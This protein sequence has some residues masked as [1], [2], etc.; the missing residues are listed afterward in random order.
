MDLESKTDHTA[1]T[2][3]SFEMS[4]KDMP[5]KGLLASEFLSALREKWFNSHEFPAGTFIS[6]KKYKHPESKHK[7]IFY[8]FNNQLDYAL[9]HYF[10]KSKTTKGNVNKF[11]TNPLIAPLTKN[12]SYKNA[13]K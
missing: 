7:N 8:P 2:N 13:I 1:T 5:W 12:L 10:T 11:L 6:D 3:G 9:A 4:T